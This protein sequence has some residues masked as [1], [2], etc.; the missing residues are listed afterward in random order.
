LFQDLHH[1][2]WRSVHPSGNQLPLGI[3]KGYRGKTSLIVPPGDVWPLVYV[4]PYWDELGVDQFNNLGMGIGGLVHYVAP[5]APGGG[6]GQQDSLTLLPGRAKSLLS[7]F[8]PM[9][10]LGSFCSQVALL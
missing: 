5:V 4:Y 10:A 8:S 7:P 2:F 6:E 9:D 3:Q 1:L